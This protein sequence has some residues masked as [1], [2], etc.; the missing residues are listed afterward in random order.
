MSKLIKQMIADELQSRYGATDSAVWI[1]FFGVDGL[2]NSEFRRNLHSK[3]MK[4]E[5]V[6][7][8]LLRR[9]VAGKPIARLADAMEGP[10]ALITGGTSSVEIAKVLK[11]WEPK[12]KNMKLRGA[13]MEGEFIGEPA[14]KDLAKMPTKRDVQGQIASAILSPGAKLASAINSPGGRI[15]G[16]L[17]T[18]IE[19]LEKGETAAPAEAAAEAASPTA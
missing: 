11:T 7:T 9:A 10:A 14:V 17:K 13:V 16:A 8:A 1:D 5:V 12:L 18:L 2:T 4:L 3:Q 15:A 6:K 19:K